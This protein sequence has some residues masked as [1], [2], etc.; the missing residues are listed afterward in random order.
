VIIGGTSTTR[1]RGFESSAFLRTEGLDVDIATS[2]HQKHRLAADADAI[3]I[4]QSRVMTAFAAPAYRP[5]TNP[6][7][8]PSVPR[9]IAAALVG[10]I[11][12]VIVSIA[13]GGYVVGSM[14]VRIASQAAEARNLIGTTPFLVAVA[15]MHL[16]AA[17]AL[18]RGRDL[19]RLA[20]VIVAGLASIAAAATAAM[21]AA[22][23]D[24]IGGTTP[25]GPPAPSTIAALVIAAVLYGTAAVAAVS[26]PPDA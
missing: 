13:I 24:P 4:P 26:D 17:V 12:V 6:A 7:A 11:A 18:A 22:G 8:S 2:V 21:L 20:A 15:L 25:S 9:L 10:A 16:L 23:V 1:G 3:S 19:I 5:S 14:H